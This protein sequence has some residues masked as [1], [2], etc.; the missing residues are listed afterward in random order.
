MGNS[1][2]A[3][4]TAAVAVVTT[5]VN[6]GAVGAVGGALGGIG[7][8]IGGIGD[9]LKDI[10]GNIIEV[11]TS[12]GTEVTEIPKQT[13]P[14]PNALDKYGSYTYI[15]G[16]SGLTAEELNDPDG[17]Y[18]KAGYELPILCKSANADPDNRINTPYGKFDFFIDQLELHS[19]IGMRDGHNTNVYDI[20]FKI[21]EPY[22][23]GLFMIACQQLA[24][25]TGH[26]NFI[27]APLLLSIEF[28]GNTDVLGIGI[29]SKVEGI[30]RKISF[31]I[32]NIEMDVTA[33]GSVYS[34]RAMPVNQSALADANVKLRSDVTISG[35]TVQETLQTGPRSLQATINA[36][37]REM[38]EQKLVSAVDEVLIIFPRNVASASGT[39][40]GSDAGATTSSTTTA[41]LNKKLGVTRSTVNQTL[42]QST[43]ECNALGAARLGFSAARAGTTPM[44]SVDKVYDAKLEVNIRANSVIDV[45]SSDFKFAQD[46]TII[47]SI[48]QVLLQ[49]TI[50]ATTFDNA[51][52]TPE[53]YRRMWRVDTQ[54]YI[55][56][57]ETLEQGVRPLLHVYRVVP[58]AAHSSSMMPPNT[59]APGYDQL[60]SQVI[61]QYDY[62]YTGKN[63]DV[64]KFDIKINN[65][66]HRQMPADGG[67][68]SQD[69]KMTATG[70]SG[71]VT[72]SLLSALLGK[73]KLPSTTTGILPS[74]VRYISTGTTSDKR[75]GGGLD[76]EGTR[77]A[78]MFMD[79]VTLGHDLVMLN[80]TILGD[81]YYI[82]Q[83]GTGNYTSAAS[84]YINLNTD[85]T[86]NY[87]NG[88]V[89]I[90]INFRTPVDI[91]QLSGLY[92]FSDTLPVMQYSGMYKLNTVISTF[93]DGSFTQ[94]LQ[95]QRM[96]QQEN[97]TEAAAAD[98]FNTSGVGEIFNND[99]WPF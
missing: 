32:T 61:K 14:M 93:A 55:I 56:G 88:E 49:S 4:T 33:A 78:R 84:Q 28:R 48:N 72:N 74:I 51:N 86:M 79:A 44:S 35:T 3:A 83:S 8:A 39:S 97:P 54:T 65:G 82:V 63:V 29:M 53:G 17:T 10:Y 45:E 77:A 58:Y 91:N 81:A 50:A 24:Q 70:S 95:G 92:T 19:M 85:G 26:K 75:G 36:R 25:E 1:N 27:G 40:S 38:V 5:L 96:P 80:M 2:N 30:D 94:V 22:S 16:I 62:I 89:V 71:G 42:V 37:L 90:G 21:T 43:E 13:L 52:L 9:V 20:S 66:F 59:R 64:L 68:K 15:L 46:S 23:M 73:G 76:N 34:I 7:G 67:F 31:S 87:Q 18:M 11:I 47:N 6:T 60:K 57:E 98:T 12:V 69:I 41:A 99:W